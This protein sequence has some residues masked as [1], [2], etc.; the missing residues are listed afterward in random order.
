[1][2]QDAQENKF[3]TLLFYRLDRFG[4]S[5]RIILNGVH[6]LEQYGIKIKSMTEPF[7][8]G[9]PSGRF[10]LTILAGVADLERSNILD[11]LWHGANRAARNGKWLGGVCPYGYRI[12]EEGFLA[13][14]T[15]SL[16]GFDMSEADV[17]QMI[18]RLTV[19]QNMSTYKI[20]DYLNALGLPPKYAIIGRK[21][22]KGK[23]KEN[24]AGVWT[25]GR[26]RNMIVQD[27][28][29]GI[30]LYGKSSKKVREVIKREVPA[31]VD[32]DTWDQAQLV[33]KDNQLEAVRYARHS[34]LL[35]SLVKCS[36]C[37]LN[38]SGT[39]FSG[40]KGQR[41][42]YYV[43]NGKTS[44]RGK[45]MGKCSAKNLAA[46]WLDE[47]VWNDCVNFINNPGQ[48]L[49]DLTPDEENSNFSTEQ[50]LL[51]IASSL[52]QKDIEKQS[53]LDLY[54]KQLITS[55]D[56]E[57][58]LSKIAFERSALE[59][60]QKE[61]KNALLTTNDEVNRK[62]DV[63]MLLD[64]LKEKLTGQI[65]HETKRNI[66]KQ[67]VREVVVCTTHSDDRDAP[68]VKLL[69]KFVFSQ[70]VNHTDKGSLP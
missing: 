34:Y 64:E 21:I 25:P 44:Y 5:A 20:A 70:V 18:F 60:R 12:D 69:V 33:L 40:V 19:N 68:E 14:S 22:T 46:D 31:I 50:E 30:H 24:T 49:I 61:L 15:A 11:R 52:S 48:L 1:M 47:K 42:A 13:V 10:L 54:R 16:P 7:D 4:R 36:L 55:K 57:E 66:I 67:L 65:T 43:C 28:Y 53:I 38:F 17:V 3:D 39:G 45:Y 62:K 32:E 29:K 26:V 58:Q 6:T 2:L 9:D 23:R 56:V 51:L 59:D 41:T 8:T 63:I 27:T 37:G 35:R